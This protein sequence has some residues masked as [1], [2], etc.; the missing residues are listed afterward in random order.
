MF[1]RL[2][3][4]LDGSPLGESAVPYGLALQ[5]ALSASVILYRVLEQ[6]THAASQLDSLEWRMEREAARRYLERIA[7]RFR[8]GGRGAVDTK[9]ATGS[10]PDAI[11]E[12]A[13]RSHVDLILLSSHGAG[14]LTSFAV[15]GTAHKVISAAET[16]V[17]FVRAGTPRPTDEPADLERIL[18]AVDGSPRGDWAAHVAASIAGALGSELMLTHVVTSPNTIGKYRTGSEE[19]RVLDRLVDLEREEAQR[20]LDTLAEQVGS[21]NIVLRKRVEVDNVPRVL[22]DIAEEEQQSLIVLGAHGRSADTGWHY[23]SVAA[24]LIQNSRT[25][26]LVLQDAPPRPDRAVADSGHGFS[27]SRLRASYAWRP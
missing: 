4:P 12:M 23:G 8:V 19:R 6:G 15:S 25:P 20:R 7:K 16:S 1:K 13:R 22:D 21:A 3:I 18:V 10:A 2:L 17:L 5:R 9:V 11:V 26:V 24:S 14:G 27:T